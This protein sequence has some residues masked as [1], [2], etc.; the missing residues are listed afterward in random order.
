[1]YQNAKRFVV[2]NV[3]LNY[4]LRWEE[5]CKIQYSYDSTCLNS[6][7]WYS[8]D[9]FRVIVTQ[10]GSHV[11]CKFSLCRLIWKKR[12]YIS[13]SILFFFLKKKYFNIHLDQRYHYQMNRCLCWLF[14]KLL[15]AKWTTSWKCFL[16][17]QNCKEISL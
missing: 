15:L 3:I 11:Y 9:W 16:I 13:N 14:D 1:M 8:L 17:N 6:R 7:G 2:M 10:K 4:L 12:F 5:P